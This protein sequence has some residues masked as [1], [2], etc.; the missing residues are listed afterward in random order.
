[1][2]ESGTAPLKQTPLAA[3]HEA[4]GGRMVP[5]A[6]YSMPVQYATGILAEHAWTREHAGLFD[7]SHMGQASLLG[8]DHEM[9]ARACEK[10]VAADILGLAPGQQRYTQILNEEGGIYD[11]LMVCRPASPIRDG[12]LLIVVNASMKEADYIHI[13][14]LLPDGITLRRHDD[15]ALLALQGPEAEAV[16]ARLAPGVAS[17][18]FMTGAE[19]ELAGIPAHVTRSG[20]TGE[21]GF[22]ISVEAG[23]AA[24]L[25]QRLTADPAVEP[26]GLGA[27]DSL[28]LEAGLPLHGHDINQETSPVEAGLAWSIGAR[29]RR[30]GGFPGQIRISQELANGPLRRRVGLVLDGRVPAREH[31]EIVD[32]AGELVGKVT[33]G[34]FGPSVGAP[35]AMGYVVPDFAAPGTELGV[36]VRGRTLPARIVKMPFHP[37]RY[38]R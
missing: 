15:R 20:Y 13:A 22:E 34:G 23:R 12:E 19:V 29:R 4:A 16:L 1:M 38:R 9:T 25:W 26:A 14:G 6:G 10:I 27:R 33:S 35:I 8:P 5:F 3:L 21:D 37:H 30:E 11:D 31:A 36:I 7:V 24:A 2:A 28:R 32:P 18:A 17:M